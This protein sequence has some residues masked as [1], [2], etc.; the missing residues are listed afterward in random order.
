MH[1]LLP[2]EIAL[3]ATLCGNEYGW[4]LSTFPDALAAAERLA[5]ACLGGQVQFRFENS[6]FEAYWLNADSSDRLP[7]ED[8]QKYVRRSC[9]EV[10]EAF[11]SIVQC[12]DLRQ[13]ANEW[14]SL[15]LLVDAGV[16]RQSATVFVAYF[17]TEPEYRARYIQFGVRA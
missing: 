14:P 13:T 10:S 15:K 2:P 9:R 3:S 6:I 17:V 1:A 5:F 7:E 11:E 4:S 8:W 16:D 12:V